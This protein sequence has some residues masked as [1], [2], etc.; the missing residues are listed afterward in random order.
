MSHIPVAYPSVQDGFHCAQHLIRHVTG[1]EELPQPQLIAHAWNLAGAGLGAAFPLDDDSAVGAAKAAKITAADKKV[2][3]RF[4]AKGEEMRAAGG[5]T[6]AIDWKQFFDIAKVALS[7][8][9]KIVQKT[10]VCLI[11]CLL[12]A[13]TARAQ[14]FD[15]KPAQPAPPAFVITQGRLPAPDLDA[16]KRDMDRINREAEELEAARQRSLSFRPA[17]DRGTAPT[18]THCENGCC[19]EKAG[20]A[21]GPARKAVGQGETL[22]AAINGG[23]GEL[24][25]RDVARLSLQSRKPVLE[26]VGDELCP[27]CVDDTKGEFLHFFTPGR[28]GKSV[29]VWLPGGDGEHYRVGTLTK[30]VEGSP[31]WGHAA[32]ARKVLKAWNEGR[33]TTLDGWA[34]PDVDP[35]MGAP[36][37]SPMWGRTLTVAHHPEAT[38]RDPAQPAFTVQQAPPVTFAPPP[39]MMSAPVMYSAPM[40]SAPRM[41]IFRGGRVR[42]GCSGGSCG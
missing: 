41:G 8:L 2:L 7:I 6:R 34:A 3:E 30:W 9:Q 27:R 17:A 31:K 42:G 40:M 36:P 13:G 35:S 29:V 25:W 19:D 28:G 38:F 1:A 39:V 14:Q 15:I 22:L 20:P 21:H 24:P 5:A 16:L 10:T 18:T 4:A 12:V 37:D 11:A 32:S 33:P 23:R 26:W